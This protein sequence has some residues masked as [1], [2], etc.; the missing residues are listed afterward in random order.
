MFA[1]FR[2]FP[3]TT[4]NVNG[5]QQIAPGHYVYSSAMQS[6]F[7]YRHLIEQVET[8]PSASSTAQ[9]RRNRLSALVRIMAILGRADSDPACPDLCTYFDKTLTAIAESGQ[10]KPRRLADIIGHLRWWSRHA[11]SVRD[12]GKPRVPRRPDS[13]FTRALLR[14]FTDSGFT[15]S[16][17]AAA[18]SMSPMTLGDWLR[19]RQPRVD[20][21]AALERVETALRLEP[22]ALSRLVRWADS[23]GS[24]QGHLGA[25]RKRIAELQRDPYRLPLAAFS[26]DLVKQWQAFLGHQ[27]GTVV[28]DLP[29]SRQAGWSVKRPDQTRVKATVLTTIAG[30]ICPSAE[31]VA[32]KVQGILGFLARATSLGGR[33]LPLAQVQTLAWLA[34]PDAVDG[35]FRFVVN[36][37]GKVNNGV[38]GMT[39]FILSM[40]DARTGWLRHHPELAD[41]LPDR[42]ASNLDWHASCQS[43]MAVCLAW[44]KRY[45]GR[46][47]NPKVAIACVLDADDALAAMWRGIA[48]LDAEAESLPRGS[49]RRSSVKRDALIL[50]LLTCI[51][52]RIETVAALNVD[53][54]RGGDHIYWL[55]NRFRLS[56]G[57]LKN[58]RRPDGEAVDI[59]L[60]QILNER[61]SEYLQ[62]HRPRIVGTQDSQFFLPST[63]NPRQL[64]RTMNAHFI[65]VTRRHVPDCAGFGP[66]ALR[67]VVASHYLRLH[68]NEHTVVAKLLLVTLG[69]VMKHYDQSGAELAMSLHEDDVE[70]AARKVARSR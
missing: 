1:D 69:T 59:A 33:G 62:E 27:T 10:F 18:A 2:Y 25:Y 40:L 51:P 43:T 61:I 15:K 38:R 46:S 17:L 44:R 23:A 11:A 52:L 13:D 56:A 16:G 49:L 60:P 65:I 48:S 39:S 47:R 7:T 6:N 41:N 37:S 29:M 14:A 20:T 63:R 22:G 32:R 67:H 54:S 58:R 4:N 42:P 21:R 8:G 45:A 53:G 12:S 34:I 30:G 66:H 9:V 36:R 3:L 31:V 50:A 28:S 64:W 24:A 57:N 5:W 35:Y 19:G 70:K 55:G 26:E 68:P